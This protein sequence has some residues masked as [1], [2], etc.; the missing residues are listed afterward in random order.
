MSVCKCGTEYTP[1]QNWC[2]SCGEY[3]AG[4]PSPAPHQ[5][6]DSPAA[7][8]NPS[9]K[10]NIIGDGSIITVQG[11]VLPEPVSYCEV[12]GETVNLRLSY[13]CPACKQNPVC[14]KHYDTAKR[15]CTNCLSAVIA[16]QPSPTGYSIQP[17]RPLP[18]VAPALQYT[19]EDCGE[20]FPSGVVRPRPWYCGDSPGARSCIGVRRKIGMGP[21]QVDSIGPTV[22]TCDQ[23]LPLEAVLKL[24]EQSPREIYV[25]FSGGGDALRRASADQLHTMTSWKW[26]DAV[27]NGRVADPWNWIP[28]T[29]FDE[30]IKVKS[31]ATR[32][33]H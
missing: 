20:S 15:M 16:N 9:N 32:R 3:L 1:P 28:G 13:K 10:F 29:W 6:I 14:S 27:V 33:N 7:A 2:D 19:C 26:H 17:D 23:S 25:G 30:I 22:G 21:R 5:P 24:C 4:E 8:I 11:P 12:A 18:A 31:E